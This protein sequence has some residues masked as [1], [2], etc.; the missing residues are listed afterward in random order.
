MNGLY[1]EIL[2][3]N[4]KFKEL[5]HIQQEELIKNEK[6]E[7]ISLQLTLLSEILEKKSRKMEKMGDLKEFQIKLLNDTSQ[8]LQKFHKNCNKNRILLKHPENSPEIFEENF[9][10]NVIEDENMLELDEIPYDQEEEIKKMLADLQNLNKIS[11]E[12]AEIVVKNGEN[13][14]LIEIEADKSKLNSEKVVQE[15]KVG[16]KETIK[17]RKNYI[18]IFFATLGG[19]IGIQAGPVGVGVGAIGGG[20][21]GGVVSL[22]L[23]PLNNKINKIDEKK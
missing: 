3:D 7:E 12:T 1:M 9:D 22:G 20:A 10:Q 2:E 11:K 16:A 4:I 15:L 19:L 5:L 21:V 14:D 17:K 13:F 6:K 18:K 23:N 8:L